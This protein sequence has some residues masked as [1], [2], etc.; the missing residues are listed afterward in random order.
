MRIGTTSFIKH[1]GRLENVL[2]L[3]DMVDEIE[4]LYTDSLH[5]YDMPD[6][7]EIAAMAEIKTIYN[8]HMPYDRNLSLMHE[9]YFIAEFAEKLK[10]LRAVTHTIHIQPDD[11]FFR[12]LEWFMT[13][14]GLPATLENG[15]DDVHLL[16]RDFKAG[17]CLD[18]GHIIMHGQD[19]SETLERLNDRIE[20]FHLHGVMGGGDHKSIRHLSD[21]TLEAVLRYAEAKDLTI[22]LEVFNEKDLTDSL[23]YLKKFTF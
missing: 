6:T 21:D 14:T 17:I 10:P 18:V 5:E 11:A 2:F 3:K 1:A 16:E 4:L 19:V 20:M 13:Q 9:W 12:G 22:S 7:N 15:G 23:N 8:I